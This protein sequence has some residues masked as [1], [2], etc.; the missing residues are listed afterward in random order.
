M[1]GT[2][3]YDSGKLVPYM[4]LTD[5]GATL[6]IEYRTSTKSLAGEHELVLYTW[7]AD[8]ALFLGVKPNLAND[9][10]RMFITFF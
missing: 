8:Y 5:L 6:N 2:E 3:F 7:L 10:T 1:Y 9:E 4:T